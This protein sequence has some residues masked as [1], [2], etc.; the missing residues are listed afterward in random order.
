MIVFDLKCAHDHQFEAWFGSSADFDNQKKRKL[1]RCPFCD[2]DNIDKAL[3]APAVGRKGNQKNESAA[4]PVASP[5][6]TPMSPAERRA[7]MEALAA[8]QA[9]VEAASEDV[10]ADFVEEVRKIH[11]GEAEDRPIMGEAKLTDARDLL[12][13]GI[14]VLPLPFQ[15]KRR[16]K[17]IQ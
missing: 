16:R 8:F 12:E 7:M 2:D 13:E 1:L 6:D 3:M 10:G 14:T 5:G 15:T 9:K 4:V 11:Y 17:G